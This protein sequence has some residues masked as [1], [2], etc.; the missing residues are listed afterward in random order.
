[1]SQYH[2]SPFEVG[3]VKAHLHHGL[4]AA[5][6]ARILLKSDG[7]SR[8]SDQAVRDVVLK[9]EADP[10]WT[11]ERTAGSGAPRKTTEK[12]DRE[13]EEFVLAERG[14]QKVTVRAVKRKF[15]ALRKLSDDL[16]EARLHEAELACMPRR[17]KCKVG[18][19]YLSERIAYCLSVKRKHQSTLLQ[20]A[21]ADGTCYY[22]ARTADEVEQAGQ[23]ALGP[24]VW[25]RTDRRDAL[26][27][28]CLGPSS[29]CKG[30]GTPV[31]IWGM[32]ANGR[33]RIH[34]MDEGDVMNEYLYIELVEDFFQEWAG[35]CSYLVQD[36]E[37]CLRTEAAKA[38][39]GRAG[40]ELVEGYPRKSQDFNA[41]E[42]GWKIVKERLDQTMPTW[43]E[44][45]EE[46]VT[47]LRAAVAWVN[48]NRGKELWYLSTNQKERADD[49]LSTEP[50]GGR[51]KWQRSASES[52]GGF[53]PQ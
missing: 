38:A 24:S 8:W 17:K 28:D 16:V 37:R 19:M 31:R 3:Q 30:Q 53:V 25:R 29:Y 32:L 47:R 43:R 1:M 45:R 34:V 35:G 21:Y 44:R 52:A 15:P 46:F 13:I 12:Q 48:R 18:K 42:N 20:W 14:K 51:T 10:S 23:A 41:I 26:F 40:L 36:F 9:L 50:R 6:I 7:V 11:G 2:M 22:L 5:A 33:L 39:I 27:E 4:R 49:C